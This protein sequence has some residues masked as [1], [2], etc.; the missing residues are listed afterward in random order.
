MKYR[1]ITIV[2]AAIMLLIVFAINTG[3]KGQAPEASTTNSSS[4]SGTFQG[5]GK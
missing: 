2:I 4:D 3:K 5:F 1:I